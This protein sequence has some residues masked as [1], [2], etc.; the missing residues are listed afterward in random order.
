MKKN[1]IIKTIASVAMMGA[2]GTGVSTSI[3]SCS[4]TPAHA[5]ETKI[6]TPSLL[7]DELVAGE[8]DSQAQCQLITKGAV[9]INDIQID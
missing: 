1:T 8:A 9:P 5:D 6:I 2:I 3:S 7:T 4:N